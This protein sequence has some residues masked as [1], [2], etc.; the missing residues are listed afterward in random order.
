MEPNKNKSRRQFLRNTSLAALSLGLVPKAAIAKTEEEGKASSTNSCDHTTLDYYGEGPFYTPNAP[1]IQNNLLVSPNEP[2]TR[3]VLTGRV[4]NL[5]CTEAI[6]DTVIDL[7]HA[8][9]AGAYDNAGFNL[10]GKTTSNSQ[11]FYVFTTIKPGKYLNGNQYR[12]SHIHFKITPPGFDALTTQLYFEGD[13]DI[14][15]DAAASITNGTFD[16]SHR[17]IPLTLNSN[18]ELEG[19][20]DI[21]INGE[22]ISGANDIHIDKGIL[23]KIYPN[24]FS[25]RIE[26]FYGVFRR[27]KVSLQ[28][29]DLQGRLVATL[30]ER[31]LS[32][33]KYTAV[34][35]PDA[36]LSN[37]YYFVALKINDL[38]V[39][40]MKIL[41]QR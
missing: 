17:I 7:W 30:E 14:P 5:D 40:Y 21:I 20:W 36:G 37:G 32:P 39:H 22:G 25:S 34:W 33:E 24:P 27:S 11:G 26:I 8:N 12:P 19:T 35:E 23:Y 13:S 31:E 4:Y 1:A 41:R 3:L 2:G 16:A 38:Q 18:G 29:Y 6:P 10:R 28:V 15:N 9:D